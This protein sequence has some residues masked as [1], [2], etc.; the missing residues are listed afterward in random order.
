M[1]IRQSVGRRGRREKLLLVKLARPR[2]L[3]PNRRTHGRGRGRLSGAGLLLLLL[4]YL[5]G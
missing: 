1:L 3:P 2:R 5:S 4:V